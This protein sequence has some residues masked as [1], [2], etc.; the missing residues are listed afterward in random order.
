M[1][2]SNLMLIVNY[3]QRKTTTF[4]KTRINLSAKKKGNL[5]GI[6]LEGQ[7]LWEWYSDNSLFHHSIR[8]ES[9]LA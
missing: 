3:L 5:K 8:Q 2:T 9:I 6:N 1:N 7:T 4:D